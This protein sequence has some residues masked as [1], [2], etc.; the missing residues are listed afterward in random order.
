MRSQ[1]GRAETREGR[2]EGLFVQG[3]AYGSESRERTT[4][5]LIAGQ[6]SISNK[7]KLLYCFQVSGW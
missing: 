1:P 2:A 3:K 4:G 6:K 5:S 7:I